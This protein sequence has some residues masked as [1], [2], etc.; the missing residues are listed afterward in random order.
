MRDHVGCVVSASSLLT[1][2]A[3]AAAVSQ[4]IT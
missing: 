1:L 2:V 4:L 3:S